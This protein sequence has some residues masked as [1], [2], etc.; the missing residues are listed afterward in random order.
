MSDMKYTPEKIKAI[1]DG[2]INKAKLHARRELSLDE[3]QAVSGGMEYYDE[4]GE[5]ILKTGEPYDYASAE[6]YAKEAMILY[7]I[8]G[9]WDTAE[10]FLL[11]MGFGL[12]EGEIKKNGFS[13]F[14][15]KFRGDFGLF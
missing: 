12:V 7:E 5:R 9:N 15:A 10:S 11:E 3:A 1:V 6:K 4:N 2:A 14:L 8:T 13:H